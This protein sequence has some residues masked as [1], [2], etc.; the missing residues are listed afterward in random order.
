MDTSSE[1][2]FLV[3]KKKKKKNLPASKFSRPHSFTGELHQIYKE[4]L[5]PIIKPVQKAEEAET[6]PILFY[7]AT[8][9]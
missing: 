3:K 7:E 9:L 5:I 2:E 6:L 1:I 4:E 8:I